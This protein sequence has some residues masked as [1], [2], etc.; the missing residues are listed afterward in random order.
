[1]TPK[2]K[3]KKLVDKMGF[4]TSHTID[5]TS[6]ESIPVYRNL[7]FKECALIAVVEIINDLKESLEVAEDLHPHAIGL[8]MGS[9]AGWQ[10]VKKELEQL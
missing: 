9:L 6:G 7:W 10:E 5:N 2:E 8:I 4:S 1:M 3:A